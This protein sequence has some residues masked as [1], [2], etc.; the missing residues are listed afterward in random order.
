MSLKGDILGSKAKSK[1]SKLT[2]ALKNAD[3]EVLWSF[4]VLCSSVK[5]VKCHFSYFGSHLSVYSSSNVS[6][7]SSLRLAYLYLYL[8][9][10]T[11]CNSEP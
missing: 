11:P 10:A 6:Q 1:I 4:F 2:R 9:S 7:A 3:L 5:L 8:L